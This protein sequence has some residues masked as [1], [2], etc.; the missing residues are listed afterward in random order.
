MS[1]TATLEE[2]YFT[3]MGQALGDKSRLLQWVLPGHVIDVGAG[4]GEF[5]AH[6]ARNGHPVTAIDSHPDSLRRL[7]QIP[8]VD[9]VAGTFG[10]HIPPVELAN[11][12]IA[13]SV[14]HEVYS[15]GRGLSSVTAAV[16]QTHDLLRPGG[17]LIIRDGVKPVHPQ[18]PARFHAPDVELV[19][20]YLRLTPHPELSLARD[21]EWF[22]GTRHAVSE[23]LLTI[24][25]GTDSLH[26]EAQ[27]RY[28]LATLAGYHS[29]IEPHG[30]SLI[31]RESYAQP[32]YVTAL[33]AFQIDSLGEPWFPPTN[34]IWV[35][36][37]V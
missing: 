34:A 26:R 30:F 28:E 6:L 19:E 1:T 33:S 7:A 36:D 14:F 17:R 4:G 5:S 16:Q 15:Y 8:G 27:E 25:W 3:R 12:V 37:R 13:S 18:A 29:L 23:A 10:G 24:T 9:A 31:H 35:F 20:E 11:T 32:G 2:R 21:G 22:H